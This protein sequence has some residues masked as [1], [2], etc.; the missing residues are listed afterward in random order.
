MSH[1]GVEDGGGV[2]GAPVRHLGMSRSSLVV[3]GKLRKARA[4]SEWKEGAR[5]WWAGVCA[6]AVPTRKRGP[7]G[8]RGSRALT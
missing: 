3:V 5:T 2:G 1:I 4:G 8:G 6:M 7:G